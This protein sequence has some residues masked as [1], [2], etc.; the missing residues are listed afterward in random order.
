MFSNKGKRRKQPSERR[1]ESVDKAGMCSCR[2]DGRSRRV[3][4]REKRGAG[5]VRQDK[6]EK[7]W[8]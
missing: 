1:D 3:E 5:I 2:L 6:V 8:T 7:V 4:H